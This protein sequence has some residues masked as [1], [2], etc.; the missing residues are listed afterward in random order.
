MA[1]KEFSQILKDLRVKAG[2]TQKQV[3]EHFSIPQSTFS[4]WEVGKSEPSG[5]MLIKL[6]EF[7]RCDIMKEFSSVNSDV[8]TLKE[9][10]HI[11]KYRCLPDSGKEMVDMVLD[12]E[13]ERV[14]VDQE[15]YIDMAARGG[16]LRITKSQAIE[17]AK[18]AKD[19]PNSANRKDLF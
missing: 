1:S 13:Y 12:K 3:Y 4:S 9:F 5:E 14:Q 7:Y 15:E 11:K 10:E 8:L 6:C 16:T 19:A 2:Y 17:L 18:A